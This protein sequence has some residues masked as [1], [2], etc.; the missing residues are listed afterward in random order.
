MA[1]MGGVMFARRACNGRI[2]PA[3][4]Q[5]TNPGVEIGRKTAKSPTIS[6]RV[7]IGLK[8]REIPAQESGENAHSVGEK[9]RE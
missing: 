9:W 1:V 5:P 2:H 3:C 7:E 4:H 8:I 6:G